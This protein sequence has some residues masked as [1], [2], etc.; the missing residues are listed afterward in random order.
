MS[1]ALPCP[2]PPLDCRSDPQY[3]VRSEAL[4]VWKTI[5][6]NT[7]KT[8]QQLLPVLMQ[9]VGKCVCG[10]GGHGNVA[11]KWGDKGQVEQGGCAPKH[12]GQGRGEQGQEK[13]ASEQQDGEA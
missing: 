13:C 2:L 7:P 1:D 11:E 3:S 4:H 8:L 12:Q 5:V 9:Q 6:V 10:G